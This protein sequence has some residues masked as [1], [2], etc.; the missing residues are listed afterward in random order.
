MDYPVTT[1]STFF[2]E[3]LKPPL[4]N[5]LLDTAEAVEC[6]GEANVNILTLPHT[7][8]FHTAYKLGHLCH[9]K[10]LTQQWGLFI[11]F[12]PETWIGLP[13]VESTK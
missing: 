13:L 10:T 11:A 9:Q 2:Y 1:L 3:I 7:L 4:R 5:A 12:L 8:A 6:L